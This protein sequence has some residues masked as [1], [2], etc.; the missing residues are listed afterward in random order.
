MALQLICDRFIEL[1]LVFLLVFTPLAYGAVH[2]GSIAIFEIIAALMV[3]LWI[4]KMLS[5]GRLEFVRNPI[6]P[7][8]FLF[9]GYVFLQYFFSQH[10]IPNT[11][12]SIRS[13]YS[14]AT[15]T[16]LLKLISYAMF[17]FVTLNIIR[18]RRQITRVLSVIIIMGFLMSIFYLMRYFGAPAPAG[19]I[20]PD[21]FSAY[22]GMIIPLS[23]GFL[24]AGNTI[25]SAKSVEFSVCAGTA[26]SPVIARNTAFPVSAG[27]IASRVIA[28]NTASRVI[29]RSTDEVGTTKQSYPAILLFFTII[30]MSAALFFTMSRG[31]MFSFI[32]ALIFIALLVSTRRSMKN[33][34]WIILAIAVFIILVIAWLGATPVVERILSF[35]AEIASRYFGGRLPIWQ[36][37]ISII[38]DNFIFGT[39]LGTFNYIF[40]KYQPLSII[41]KHYTYAHSDFLELL[42]EVGIVGFVLFVAGGLC[43]VVYLFRC[44]RQ[45][46]DPWVTGMSICVFGSLIAIFIHSFTDF[47][48]HIP[49]NAVLLAIILA[50]FISIL[51]ANKCEASVSVIARSLDALRSKTADDE[52]ISY[53]IRITQYLAAILAASLFVIYTIAVIQPAMADHYASLRGP[54]LS[55]EAISL[56]RAIRLDPSNAEY[57]YKL[58]KLYGKSRKYDL[59]LAKYQDAVR[60][61]PTNSQYHQSLAWTYGQLAD[62]HDRLDPSLPAAKHFVSLRGAERRSNLSP[63]DYTQTAITRFEAAIELN[64][65]YYYDYQVYAIWLFN[66]PTKENIVKGVQIYRKAAALN[67]KLADKTLFE[68]FKIEKRYV[69]LK[70]ILPDTPENHYKVM[71]MLLDAGLWEANESEFKEDMGR[72]TLKYPYYKTISDYYAKSEDREK[73]VQTL[74]EYLKID[75]GCADANFWVADRSFYCKKY[76]WEFSKKYHE[77]AVELE[78]GNNFYRLWYAIHLSYKKDYYEAARQFKLILEKDKLNLEAQTEL[79]K[80]YDKINR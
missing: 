52:A 15:K 45:R 32:A 79:A 60:L 49:A 78:P 43:V 59:Q 75:P 21:H 5:L 74:E 19:F 54:D 47:N 17:F 7:C 25:V 57:H 10:A 29:A 31:G 4:F 67:P 14:W 41:N 70:K 8:I 55:S 12:Y 62:L 44:F 20:N 33:K 42:S 9:I 24:F 77:K 46:H 63:E 72:A 36:G 11:P 71:S 28:K 64:P 16:E 51:N 40:P 22:L 27:N 38:K 35:K 1:L 56:S 30:I 53:N 37:T 65:N 34:G 23:F 39:G 76:T 58:G 13:I 73:S 48:L 50:L 2:S 66:H 69:Q 68:Y 18:T 80:I 6:T 3:M 26:A 61:N